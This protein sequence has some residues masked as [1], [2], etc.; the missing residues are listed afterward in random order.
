MS[1]A[2]FVQWRNPLTAIVARPGGLRVGAALEK[3]E[4][5]LAGIR[6]ECLTSFDEQLAALLTLNRPGQP[7][8]PQE[9]RRETYRIANEL[10]GLAGVFGMEALGKAAYSLCELVDRLESLGKWHQPAVD[11]HVA[12]LQLMR[13][14]DSGM[15]TANLLERLHALVSQAEVIAV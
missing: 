5:N 15:D 1:S 4:E 12:A 10:Y 9:S 14:H 7:A 3:A 2:I 11:V 8:P 6:D 13:S